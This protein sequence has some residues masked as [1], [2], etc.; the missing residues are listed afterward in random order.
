MVSASFI[1]YSFA[2][3]IVT[4]TMLLV[5]H[6][7]NP[8]GQKRKNSYPYESGIVPVGDTNIRWNVNYFLI[9]ISFVIFDIEAVYLYLWS[10]VVLETS[11][12]GLTTAGLF[13]LA[14][15]IALIYEIKQGAFN[16][17]KRQQGE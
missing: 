1:F 14:L 11:W 16:W 10:L 17:G 9:A 12:P 4:L 6:A 5:S 13:I 7:L 2:I 8:R 15:F 3:I